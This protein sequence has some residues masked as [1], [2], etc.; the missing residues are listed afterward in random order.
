MK[1]GLHQIRKMEMIK[2][3][4]SEYEAMYTEVEHAKTNI[5]PKSK[6]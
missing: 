5:H 1:V 3:Q 4:M 6:P 2:I